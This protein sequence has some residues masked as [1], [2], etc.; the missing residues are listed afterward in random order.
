MS[1]LVSNS[2]NGAGVIGRVTLGTKD[3]SN[4]IYQYMDVHSG[5]IFD[6]K[7]VRHAKANE[8]KLL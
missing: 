8:A 5:R 6:E 4:I 3:A 7:T 2:N 1:L